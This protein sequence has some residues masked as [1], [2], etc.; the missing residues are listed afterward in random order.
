MEVG[1]GG[2]CQNHA[3]LLVAVGW[4]SF[5]VLAQI[6]LLNMAEDLALGWGE[7]NKHVR[8][9]LVQLT[10]VGQAGSCRP[11]AALLV[12]L[13]WK[14]FL[15]VVQILR[16]NTAVNLAKETHRSNKCVQRTLVRYMVAGQVGGD[17]THAVNPVAVVPMNVLEPVPGPVHVMA[18]DHAQE[19][20]VKHKGA[21]SRRALYTVVGQVGVDGP[22]AVNPVAV[23]PK[24]VLE[25][26]PVPLHV[27]VGDHA[28]EQHG[29]RKSA[30]SRRALLMA[31][32]QVGMY[33]QAA[34]S[35]AMLEHK[36]D[37]GAALIHDL[38]M[39]GNLVQE[40]QMNNACVT[41]T[42]VQLMADG[43]AGLWQNH[44]VYLAARG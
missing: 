21:I 14:F 44:A 7:R 41:R 3:A 22:H 10:E 11:P 28:Q 8:R 38:E 24:N 6:P 27:M 32:G 25:P 43:Q 16:L 1:Q 40:R 9:I 12:A 39:A 5:L 13:E 36:E 2:L 33:G 29:K 26:V 19:Q 15:V 30:I 20:H 4:K 37:H 42:H 34:A 35:R 31:A 17:G 23:V 18:G